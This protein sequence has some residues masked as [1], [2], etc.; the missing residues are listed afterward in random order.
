MIREIIIIVIIIM[1]GNV[2]V[3]YLTK[4]HS[5]RIDGNAQLLHI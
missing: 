1:I 4:T 2:F 3:K 5:I